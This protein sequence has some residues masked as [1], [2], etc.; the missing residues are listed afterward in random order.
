MND[1]KEEETDAFWRSARVLAS[2]FAYLWHRL[3]LFSSNS[4]DFSEI[5]LVC[6]GR[7]DELMDGR[8]DKPSY[9]DARTHLKGEKKKRGKDKD[10]EI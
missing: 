1:L 4:T 8:R 7:M 9:R 3:V 5:Q 6:D 2:E 10:R